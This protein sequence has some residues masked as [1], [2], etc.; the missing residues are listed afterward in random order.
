MG[1]YFKINNENNYKVSTKSPV[2]FYCVDHMLTCT[3]AFV[4]GFRVE[5]VHLSLIH[6]G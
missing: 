2:N 4:V 1:K 5:A 3:L 6:P